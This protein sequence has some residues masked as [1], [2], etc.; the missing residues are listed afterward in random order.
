MGG[1]EQSL[2]SPNP[3]VAGVILAGGAA[4][5]LGGGD[6]G[7]QTVGGATILSRVVETLAPQVAALALNANGENGANGESGRFAELGLPVVA[8]EAGT[9]GPLAGLLAGL[10]WAERAGYSW[11]VTVPTDTP[12]LSADLLMRLAVGVQRGPAAIA[13]SGG[14]IHPVIGLWPVSMAASL[15]Q[16]VVEHGRR[17]VADWAEFCGAVRV[18][19]PDEPVDPFFNVNTAADLAAANSVCSL[20]RPRIAAVVLPAKQSAQDLLAEFAT[21]LAAKGVRLGGLIQRGRENVEMVDLEAGTAFPIMQRLGSGACCAVD[22]QAVAAACMVVRG[23]V[24]RHCDLVI[25]NKFGHLEAEGAG[26]ADEMMAA[27]A[28]D[29][30]LLTTVSSTRVEA[31]LAFCGGLCDLIPPEPSALWR[32]WEASRGIR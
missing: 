3:P 6:K 1:E 15:R 23:A 29:V 17:K 13:A 19:W 20:K 8:D 25:V 9:A 12:F 26:L 30:P 4:S 28:E 24:E 31:W 16:F 5:R 22:T 32:W 11:L 18:E 2:L 10:G 14:R 21:G 27:M 7:R